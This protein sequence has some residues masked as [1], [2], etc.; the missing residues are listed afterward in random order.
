MRVIFIASTCAQGLAE[1]TVPGAGMARVCLKIAT[2]FS[3]PH[4]CARW[5]A[6]G[7]TGSHSDIQRFLCSVLHNY[8]FTVGRIEDM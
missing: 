4:R 5:A 1:R 2:R 8:N 6:P 3:V 7:Q